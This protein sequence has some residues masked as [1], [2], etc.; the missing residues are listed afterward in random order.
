MPPATQ[1]AGRD[2]STRSWDGVRGPC[3]K[4]RVR[5][6]DS[7]RTFHPSPRPLAS[8][9]PFE[10]A[11]VVQGELPGGAAHLLTGTQARA[12]GRSLGLS[13]QRAAV[14]RQELDAA[15]SC[16]LAQRHPGNRRGDRRRDAASA[17]ARATV[18]APS[19][20]GNRAQESRIKHRAE[21]L[22]PAT[23]S[24]GLLFPVASLHCR[25]RN[26]LGPLFCFAAS[27]AWAR[28]RRSPAMWP[29]WTR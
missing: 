18:H 10:R 26:T 13:K 3:A 2:H 6:R 12:E 27:V 15:D 14:I 23:L 4:A 28:N 16:R 7:Q 19:M 25:L 5:A 9:G 21:Y 1:A 17:T 20:A 8:C 22:P 24:L 11:Q 29:V